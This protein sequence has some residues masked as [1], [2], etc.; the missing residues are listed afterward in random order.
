MAKERK[1]ILEGVKDHIVSSL[2]GKE[3]P[4]VM[5]KT[6]MDLYQNNND[7]MKLSLKDKL[8]KK[9]LEKGKTIPK[10]LDQVHSVS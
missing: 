4:P 1:I 2:D 3:A 6:L 5:W 7:Q 9:K 8:R 10:I